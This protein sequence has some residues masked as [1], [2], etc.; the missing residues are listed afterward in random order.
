MVW[1]EVHSLYS[2]VEVCKDISFEWE[3]M[4]IYAFLAN[5][6]LIPGSNKPY[7]RKSIG[8]WLEAV[9]IRASS[10]PKVSKMSDNTLIYLSRTN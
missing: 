3:S 8:R 1:C 7:L 9:S 10:T 4:T 6:N 2:L 5:L